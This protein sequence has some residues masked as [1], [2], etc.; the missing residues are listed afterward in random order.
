M[1]NV[2]VGKELIVSGIFLLS[3]TSAMGQSPTLDMTSWPTTVGWSQVAVGG[4]SAALGGGVLTLTSPVNGLSGFRAP[5]SLWTTAAA[6][7]GGFE[8]VAEMRVV[9]ASVPDTAAAAISYRNGVIRCIFDIHD[10]RV[11]L[12]SFSN[13]SGSTT[14]AMDTTDGFHQY[15]IIGLGNQV[16][17]MVDG[18][19]VISA[20]NLDSDTGAAVMDFGDDHPR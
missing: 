12:S 13:W 2:R 16:D 5:S 19:T 9:S 15:A 17:V 4:G 14:H 3:A 1:K 18:V 11:E 6:D 7:P 20:T 8:I 10:D